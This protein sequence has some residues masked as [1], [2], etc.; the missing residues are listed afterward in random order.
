VRYS[1]LINK[2]RLVTA[3]LALAAAAPALAG[4][5]EGALDWSRPLAGLPPPADTGKPAV[6]A[7]QPVPLV[8]GETGGCPPALPCGTR[9]FGTI[10]KNGAIELQVPAL[11]W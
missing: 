10:R 2:L 6:L 9:L 7:P 11:R 5:S 3:A 1:R 8:Q 4:Q